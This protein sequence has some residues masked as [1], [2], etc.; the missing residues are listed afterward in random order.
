VVGEAII[1]QIK[2]FHPMT[3]SYVL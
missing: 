1:K 3:S 2:S